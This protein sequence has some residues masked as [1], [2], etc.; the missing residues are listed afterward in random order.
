M[1]TQWKQSVL[2]QKEKQTIISL[3]EKG[4]KGTNLALFLFNR[5]TADLRC[6]QKQRDK[7]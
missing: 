5:Q 3:L 7:A 1:S 4:E 6:M 2:S